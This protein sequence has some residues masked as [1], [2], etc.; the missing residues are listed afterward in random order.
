MV[1]TVGICL[2]CRR[3]GFDSQVRKIP[4][5][6][7]C[8]PAP[9]YL[10]EKFHE[11]RSLAGLMYGV[12]KNQAQ[13]SDQHFCFISL[14]LLFKL[15]CNIKSHASNTAMDSSFIKVSTIPLNLRFYPLEDT[16]LFY[17]SPSKKN[18]PSANSDATLVKCMSAHGLHDRGERADNLPLNSGSPWRWFGP[19]LGTFDSVQ[20]HFPLSQ[21]GGWGRVLL[22]STQQ[23]L[24][25]PPPAHRNQPPKNRQLQISTAPTLRNDG[26]KQGD[27]LALFMFH[28]HLLDS[29]PFISIELPSPTLGLF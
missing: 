25:P 22:I 9:I 27:L 3:P 11:Q 8:L 26:L 10:P 23:R 29:L 13:L 14:L 6:R 12:A 16:P 1:Q 17:A 19:Y 20:R 24:L 4:W 2:Q 5:R 18:I 28:Q 7:E 15:T 21:L